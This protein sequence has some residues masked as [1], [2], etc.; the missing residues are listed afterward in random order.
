M[1]TRKIIFFAVLVAMVLALTGC[2]IPSDLQGVYAP[3]KVVVTQPGHATITETIDWNNGTWSTNESG[4]SSYVLTYAYWWGTV[5]NVSGSK[6]QKAQPITSV[7]GGIDGITWYGEDHDQDVEVDGDNVVI[8]DWLL[9]DTFAPSDDDDY[10][11]M[12]TETVSS[13]GVT[14]KIYYNIF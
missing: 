13:S 11:F 6:A 14:Y 2:G 12:L 3:A 5:Y 7:A 1:K 4:V 8:G 10:R 9:N